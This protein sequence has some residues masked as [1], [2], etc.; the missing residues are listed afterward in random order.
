[1]YR[2]WPHIPII[3]VSGQMAPSSDEL[4][5]RSR[6]HSKPYDPRLVIRHARELVGFGGFRSPFPLPRARDK[7]YE[8][9]VD[10]CEGGSDQLVEP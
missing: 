2:Q 9:L 4:P 6:F 10:P 8:R 3:V 1:M 7:P 5:P